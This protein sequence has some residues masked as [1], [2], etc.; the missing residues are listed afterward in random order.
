MNRATYNY[1]NQLESQLRAMHQ[2]DECPSHELAFD[3]DDF[4]RVFGVGDEQ[5]ERPARIDQ[6]QFE[7][8]HI[9]GDFC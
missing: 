1:L 6:E 8:G 7:H 3:E 5:Q 2:P 4:E 9:D